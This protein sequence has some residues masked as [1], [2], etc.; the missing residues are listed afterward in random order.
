MKKLSIIIPAYN[1]EK[2][3]KKTLISYLKIFPKANFIVIADGCKDNT[4]KIVK[5]IKKRKNITLF[6]PKERLG[7]GGALIFG[8]KHVKSNTV[9]FIDADGSVPPKEFRKL[10]QNVRKVDGVIASRHLKGS[11]ISGIPAM[12]KI[13]SVTFSLLVKLVFNLPFKDTQCGAKL[14]KKKM[15]KSLIPLVRSKGYIFDIELLYRAI[16]QG[17]KIKEIPIEWRYSAGSKITIKSMMKMFFNLI[18]LRFE[19]AGH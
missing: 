4:V 2:R 16:K 9:G 17:Y 14:F 6:A 13:L 7:K 5:R 10:V 15:I 12:R 3:I 11:K 18:K 1:E 8:F 19:Y